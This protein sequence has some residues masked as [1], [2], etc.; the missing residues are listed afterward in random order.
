MPR[1]ERKAFVDDDGGE[2]R[3][4]H[5][6][7]ERVLEAAD[8]DRLIDERVQRPAQAPPFGGKSGPARRGRAGDDQD[9]EIGP[10]SLGAPKRRRQ[11]VRRNALS[12]SSAVPIARVLAVTSGS[13]RCA[14]CG[15]RAPRSRAV[16]SWPCRAA[17][18]AAGTRIGVEF[19][20]DGELGERGIE[21]RAVAGFGD[22]HQAAPLVAARPGPGK[23][24]SRSGWL[25]R[26]LPEASV[27]LH[28][29]ARRAQSAV[30][31]GA[32]QDGGISTQM[33]TRPMV[34]WFSQLS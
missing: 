21:F 4:E 1:A 3:V 34:R 17:P 2:I 19:L 28:L 25:G 27:F 18:R 15:G 14:G 31:A 11:H 16:S 29:V 13:A 22:L 26:L 9:F 23:E 30:R 10:M 5:G 7:A 33:P 8:E 6:R 12:S 24:T 20:R 32:T